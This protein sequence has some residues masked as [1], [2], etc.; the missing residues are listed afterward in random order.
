MQH[1]GLRSYLQNSAV[2]F[3]VHRK[4]LCLWNVLAVFLIIY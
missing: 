4:E 2:A 3:T 1:V